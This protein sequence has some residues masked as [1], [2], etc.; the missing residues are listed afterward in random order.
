MFLQLITENCGNPHMAGSPVVEKGRNT[1]VR[2][3]GS[4][5]FDV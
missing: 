4:A 3:D 2:M 1:G 5:M